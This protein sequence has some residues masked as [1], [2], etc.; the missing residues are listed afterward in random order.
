MI[1]D[2]KDVLAPLQWKGDGPMPTKKIT[3][4]E[5]Y[6]L[7]MHRPPFMAD[8]EKLIESDREDPEVDDVR[9][10]INIGQ[11]EMV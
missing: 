1:A 4:W 2:L 9:V 6:K 7:W 10:G 8:E 3:L 5:K 11:I